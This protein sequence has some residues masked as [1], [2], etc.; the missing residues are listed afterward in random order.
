MTTQPTSLDSLDLEKQGSTRV[1]L[2]SE[3]ADCDTT[4]STTEEKLDSWSQEVFVP[5]M[6][7]L[8]IYN[9]QTEAHF[10]VNVK[11]EVNFNMFMS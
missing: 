6:T 5:Q 10:R 2:L 7:N 1:L 4:G 11:D 9:D 3:C 8:R